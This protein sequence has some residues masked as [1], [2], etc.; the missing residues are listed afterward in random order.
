MTLRVNDAFTKY[1]SRTVVNLSPTLYN[2]VKNMYKDDD[3]S[4]PCCHGKTLTSLLAH[5]NI[6]V[7]SL[8]MYRLKFSFAPH[9]GTGTRE[10]FVLE[11][12]LRYL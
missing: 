3:D 11:F 12:L 4:L 2:D 10:L 8:H 6:Y 1:G 5:A 7:F 9:A